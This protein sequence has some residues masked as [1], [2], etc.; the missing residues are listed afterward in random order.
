MNFETALEKGKRGEEQGL[1]LGK[2]GLEK[3]SNALN[4]VQK[5]RIITLASG[6]KVGKS[7]LVDG[8]FIIECF[9]DAIER[10][11]DI[12]IIYFSF[13]IDRVSKEFDFAAHFLYRDYGIDHAVLPTGVKKDGFST[14]P[15]SG[16][17]LRGR[18]MDDDGNVIIIDP[19][20]EKTLI[21]VYQERI[22]PLFG[23]YSPKGRRLSPGLIIFVEHRENPTGLRNKLLAH[24]EKHGTFEKEVL[25]KKDRGSYTKYIGYTPNNPNKFTLVVTDHIRKLHLEN[26]GG[27][28]ATLKQCIDK[29]SEYC[30]EI[31]NICQYSFIHIIHLNRNMADTNRMKY[32]KDMLYPEPADIK[33]SGNISED[34]DTVITLFN[35]NDDRY[36]L[37]KHFG[38]AIRDEA[39]N[40]LYPNMRTIHIVEN[41]HGDAPQHFRTE[42]LGNVKY[43]KKLKLM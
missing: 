30:V 24:A 4:G 8:G 37:S 14:V 34:S 38:Q 32:A 40:L 7:T 9:L 25:K 6:P 15:I 18:L 31:R 20:I 16:N 13:E 3:L 33:D 23:K 1:S 41:R 17:Y 21:K 43:F 39:G 2:D 22:I 27:K 29:Y 12:E 19:D 5:G 28:S 10:G 11:V 36:N 35:P 42:M 26:I